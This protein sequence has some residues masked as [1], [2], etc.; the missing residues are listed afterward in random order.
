MHHLF[1]ISASQDADA[2]RMVAE[3]ASRAF[4]HAPLRPLPNVDAALLDAPRDGTVLLIMVEP[5]MAEV[6]LAVESVNA[7]GLPR[8]AYVILGGDVTQGG[9]EVV[10]REEWSVPL[11]RHVLRAAVDQFELAREN[12]RFRGDLHTL[13]RR[14]SHD[15]RTPLSGIFTTTELLQEVMTE[16]CPDDVEL[17][18]PLYDSAQAELRLID[19]V[20]LLLKATVE[21]KPKEPVEMG[22]IVWEARQPVE[23]LIMQKGAQLTEARTWPTVAGVPAWLQVIWGNLLSNAVVHGGVSAAIEAGWTQV[24]GAYQFWVRDNGP[25]VPAEKQPLLF[26]PFHRLHQRGSSH[27]LGLSITQRLVDLQGGHCGYRTAPGGGAEFYFTL[28]AE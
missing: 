27:G 15:L 18:K 25:G 20:S 28:P 12:A 16:S 9:A 10:P 22:T 21:P 14:I 11:L 26:Q 4:P 7:E 3:A 2:A 13:A 8:W 23:R 17:L 1:L 6:K 24:D 5:E 19:R